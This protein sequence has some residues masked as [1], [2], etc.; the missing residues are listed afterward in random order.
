MVIFC[1][2]NRLRTYG[3]IISI[4][5]KY[6][7]MEN[8]MENR[9]L[10]Y[11]E[12]NYNKI[13]KIIKIEIILII[14]S[15]VSGVC[16]N[17]FSLFF[18]S[19]ILSFNFSWVAIILGY[20]GIVL[21]YIGK[22][23]LIALFIYS[24]VGIINTYIILKKINK[25]IFTDTQDVNLKN[26]IIKKSKIIFILCGLIIL[27][28]IGGLFYNKQLIIK[29]IGTR[30]NSDKKEDQDLIKKEPQKIKDALLNFRKEALATQEGFY[31]Y[32]IIKN[33]GSCVNPVIGSFFN[34]YDTTKGTS[35]S[36][37]KPV[38]TPK[39]V[40]DPQWIM[41]GYTSE[42][43]RNASFY[44]SSP[45]NTDYELNN[46]DDTRCFSDEDHFAF[47]APSYLEETYPVFYCVDD[48]HSDIQ[49][50]SKEINGSSCDKIN[51]N[52]ISPKNRPLP[53][54]YNFNRL[55]HNN[56]SEYIK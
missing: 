6:K 36:L 17:I 26:K 50:N 18:L 40:K 3:T 35:G 23:S 27:F 31:G 55:L 33:D 8:S 47:Q 46:K 42:H 2:I 16:G 37:L 30:N 45:F 51:E 13:R 1:T 34:P 11:I 24:F 28:I 56:I 4:I 43:L 12:I 44:S 15:V 41:Y 9:Q 39:K 14:V 19:S 53:D 21:N 10:N 5:N 49:V 29:S 52:Y 22:I 54:L 48:I 25:I 38:F 32:G 20:L 7:N